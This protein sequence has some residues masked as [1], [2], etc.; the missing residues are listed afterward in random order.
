MQRGRNDDQSEH[1]LNAYCMLG[2]IP[3]RAVVCGCAGRTWPRVGV[4]LACDLK[5]RKHE[6]AEGTAYAK[7]LRQHCAWYVGGTSK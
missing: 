7:A 5:M 4:F 6:Q 3:T 2:P 1:L